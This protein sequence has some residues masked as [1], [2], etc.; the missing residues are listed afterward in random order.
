M[1]SKW[2]TLKRWQKWAIVL[3]CLGLFGKVL[4]VTGLVPKTENKPIK[5]VQTCLILNMRKK[6]QKSQVQ[7]QVLRKKSLNILP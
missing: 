1:L 6:L 3:V 7:N 2:K 5:T 4:E